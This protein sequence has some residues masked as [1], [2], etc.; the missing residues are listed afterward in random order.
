MTRT[1]LSSQLTEA[2]QTI[3]TLRNDLATVERTLADQQSRQLNIVNELKLAH[4]EAILKLE[5]TIK[6][7]DSTYSYV[8]AEKSRLENEIEQAHAVLDSVEGAPSR[9][10]EKDYGKGQRNII[11]RLAGAFLAIAKGK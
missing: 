3:A 8:S 9:E 1:T 2:N 10:Y 4:G 11:T 6:D 7:K 5:K